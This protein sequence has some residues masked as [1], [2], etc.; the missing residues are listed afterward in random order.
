MS[1][2]MITGILQ[3]A[4]SYYDWGIWITQINCNEAS[5]NIE[6]PGGCTQYHFGDEGV[7]KSFNFEG[8]QYIGNQN[9]KICI[10]AAPRACFIGVYADPNHFMLQVYLYSS[11]S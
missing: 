8:V 1:P 6:A 5:G 9:Y 7:I 11:I 10:R 3:F 2:G 4:F